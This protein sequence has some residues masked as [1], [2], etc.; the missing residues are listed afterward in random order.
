MAYHLRSKMIWACMFW[1]NLHHSTVSP[2]HISQWDIAVGNECCEIGTMGWACVFLQAYCMLS[3]Q[4]R[5]L[6]P[7]TKSIMTCG[8]QRAT[9]MPAFSVHTYTHTHTHT[10]THSAWE[11]STQCTISP[12]HK[13]IPMHR[14][15]YMSQNTGKSLSTVSKKRREKTVKYLDST[16]NTE[17]RLMEPERN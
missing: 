2:P 10:H 6:L 1:L 9:R 12:E 13:L 7:M 8:Q 11:G 15:H 16:W 14:E 3:C 5:S 4:P 17:E